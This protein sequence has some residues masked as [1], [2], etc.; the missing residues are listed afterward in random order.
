LGGLSIIIR[1][2]ND[3]LIT[4]KGLTIK[5]NRWYSSSTIERLKKQLDDQQ[6]LKVTS[7]GGIKFPDASEKGTTIKP[8]RWYS[9]STIERLKKQ[10]DDQQ[11]LKVTPDGGI[12]FPDASEK[13]TTIKPNRWYS[14]WW[15]TYPGRLSL[16]KEVMEERFPQFELKSSDGQLTWHGALKSH[17]NNY[18]EIAVVYPSTYPYDSPEAYVL[19]PKVEAKHMYKNGKL[20]LMYPTDRTWGQSSTAATIIALVAAWIFSYEYWNEHGEWPGAEAD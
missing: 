1:T 6:P 12:K 17:H 3:I 7:D 15:K 11:P 16:E 9:S 5:P 19:D 20:C 8:N 14:D 4:E 2:W 13:G 10:L 18:Y